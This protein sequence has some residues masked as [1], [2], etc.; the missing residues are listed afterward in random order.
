MGLRAGTSCDLVGF[1]GLFLR[2]REPGAPLHALLRRREGAL[3]GRDLRAVHAR[4]QE[5]R[6]R[7]RRHQ[8]HLPR[9]VAQLPERVRVQRRVHLRQGAGGTGES[10]KLDVAVLHLLQHRRGSESQ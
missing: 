1:A 6:P 10:L 8:H 2:S 3:R 4:V 7:E 9:R 5:V